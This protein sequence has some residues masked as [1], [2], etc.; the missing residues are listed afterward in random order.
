MSQKAVPYEDAAPFAQ[1]LARTAPER[2]IWGSDW[3]HV[4]IT[5][6]TKMPEPGQLLDVL[7]D[8]LGHDD[9]LLHAVLVDNPLRLYG[10]PGTPVRG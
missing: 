2:V 9:A 8:Q 10:Y 6:P 1:A 4:A 7:A 3:P 5:D